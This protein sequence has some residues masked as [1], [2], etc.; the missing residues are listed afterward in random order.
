MKSWQVIRY[1]NIDYEEEI[2]KTFFDEK[3]AVNWFDDFC[4]ETPRS[5]FKEWN[6]ELFDCYGELLNCTV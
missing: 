2:Y 4:L 5:H 1:N 6:Y 3:T